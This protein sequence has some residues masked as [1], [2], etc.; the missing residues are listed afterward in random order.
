[1]VRLYVFKPIEARLIAKPA[2]VGDCETAVALTDNGEVRL[3][4]EAGGGSY[5]LCISG[6][7]WAPT[8]MINGIVMHTALMDP[9]KYTEDKL[10]G[11]RL[12]GR[13][14]LDCCTGLGYTALVE[15]RRG[16]RWVISI[17]ADENVLELARYNPWSRHLTD[18]RID[19]FLGD[20]YDLLAWIRDS[21]I[22]V[23]V[24]DPPRP[25][26]SWG[27]LYSREL[28]KM[29]YRALARG[30]MLYHYVPRTG[31]RYRGVN[32]ARGVANRLREAGFTIIGENEYGILAVKH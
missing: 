3:Y 23:V 29:Y 16:A 30:G 28:Y 6:E 14:V 24:H 13:V 21:S 10:R 18:G 31:S 26:R 11:V 32:L 17:E 2:N 22:G 25:T 8:L 4:L 27:P 7:G 12:R 1:M 9:I 19:L 5:R 20:I 15:L